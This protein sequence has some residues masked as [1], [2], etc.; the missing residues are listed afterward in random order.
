MPIFGVHVPHRKHT[1]SCHAERMPIPKTVVIPMSMHI[2]APAKPVVAVGDTVGVGQL[3]GEAGGFVSSPVHASV[4]GTVKK[5]DTM[6][7]TNGNPMTAI[8]IETDGEQRPYEGITPPTV[9]NYDEFVAAVRASGIVGL[10]GAGFPTCVKLSVK[11]LSKID[12]VILNGA[13][14]EP[15]I[16]ADT[17][18]MTDRA[19]EIFEGIQ[20]LEKYL[21]VKNVI[22][23]IEDNKPEAI[24]AMKALSVKDPAIDVRA[25]PASY[26]QG[27]EKVLIYNTVK[28]VVPEG[29]LPLDAGCIVMNVTTF[30]CI[31]QY[32]RTGMPLIEKCL[33]VDGSAVAQPKNVIAPIG[34]SMK[35]VFDFCGG[36][37][38]EPKKVIY[39]G[40]MMG[41]AVADLDQPILKNTN[42]IL[43][44]N[45]KE[46]ERPE[47]TPCIHCGNCIN[48]CP[49]RLNPP[50][51]AKALQQKD[52][53]ALAELKPN[54]CMECGA[55]VFV[56]PARRN[57][58]A[59]H[60]LAKIE[61][62]NYQTKLAEEQKQKEAENNGK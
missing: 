52:G 4:S 50:A 22:I 60:K 11:D 20:L 49:M 27:G 57:I 31:A 33:T 41:I 13:E 32:I 7:G 17:L 23:G 37:K 46:A 62:R 61:L 1:A 24:A 39:G 36:F 58:V 10:G 8:T 9:T 5:I 54:L 48:H 12:Y 59:R 56:C 42:A 16:T 26:P 55:C 44:F 29:K 28:R 2:G 47:E 34:T 38:E 25:L 21:G 19:D 45:A 14:C 18:T 35:D 15:Y 6:L 53:A 3:I 30:S 40:P 51:I 43:A